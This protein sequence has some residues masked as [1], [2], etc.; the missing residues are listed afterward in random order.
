M[1]GAGIALDRLL[2]LAHLRREYNVALGE[3]ALD[4]GEQL[5]A[6]LNE[7]LLEIDEGDLGL[8]H[9]DAPR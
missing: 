7:A 9:D 1:L 4:A 6:L 2:E 8:A 3:H 5:L